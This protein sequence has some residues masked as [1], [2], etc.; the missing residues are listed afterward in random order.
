MASAPQDLLLKSA[1]FYI[2]LSENPPTPAFYELLEKH[3]HIPRDEADEHLE[4]VR[5]QAWQRFPYPNIGLF[6]FHSLGLSGD[7]LPFHSRTP[8][9]PG[10]LINHWPSFSNSQIPYSYLSTRRIGRAYERILQTLKDGGRFLDVG[11]KL[12]P[13]C[14]KLVHDGAPPQSVYGTDLFSEFFDLGYALFRDEAILPR[15]HFIQANFLDRFHPGLGFLEGQLDVVHFADVLH[16]FGIDDQTSLVQ[17]AFE[18]LK[19]R[20]GVMVTGHLAG[21][22]RSGFRAASDD[23]KATAQDKIWEHSS[24]SI[25]AL[26]EET[27]T[28]VGQ[29][30]RAECWF[31]RFGVHTK[32]EG[33]EDWPRGAEHGLITFIAT[34][35][36]D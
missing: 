7:H 24:R 10:P 26:F 31:W 29:I 35:L 19:P 11:C 28:R 36:S 34:R 23:A 4:K 13:D 32:V 20:K 12:A 14:R 3:S 17:R 22:M 27:G 6:L 18:M 9:P 16:L 25:K 15:H 1:P 5:D 8:K 21:N 30:W 2:S 33:K